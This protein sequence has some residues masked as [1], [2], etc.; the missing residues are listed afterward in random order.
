MNDI[1]QQ[2]L[3]SGTTIIVALLGSGQLWKWFSRKSDISKQ[4]TSLTDEVRNL[5]KKIEMKDAKQCRNRIVRFDDEL[6]SNAR[7]SH[8]GFTL[9]LDDITDYERYCNN[10]PGF[11]NSR[12]VEATR[13]IKECYRKCEEKRDFLKA[14]DKSG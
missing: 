10:N 9:I 13:H 3:T 2:L 11:P 14:E 12:A 1:I 6:L 8:E 5:D 4:I 7:H